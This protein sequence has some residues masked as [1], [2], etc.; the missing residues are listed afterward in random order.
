MMETKKNKIQGIYDEFEAAAAPYKTEATCAKGCAFCC[1]DAG[2]IDTT[3]LEGLVIRDAIAALPRSRQVALKKALAADRVRRERNQ[4]SACPLLMKNRACMI[5]RARPFACRRIY[6][7]KACSREQP[8]MLNH[9]V[10]TLGDTAINALQRLDD[11]GYSG[12]LSY[13]LHMLNTPAFLNP[14]LA[15][16]FNPQAVMA[17]GKTHKIAINRMMV[18]S[19]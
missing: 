14:Y 6:S 5:Y 4:P 19:R 3:T 9:Q 7:L 1:T 18:A 2:S 15:G 8:P 13:V 10:M 16:E 17:F 11:T 12:H